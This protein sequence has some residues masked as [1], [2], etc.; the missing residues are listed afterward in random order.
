MK[1]I[2]NVLRQM[3]VIFCFLLGISINQYFINDNKGFLSI[4]IFTGIYA[5]WFFYD[6]FKKK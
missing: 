4:L 3:Y 6:L 2:V 5:L 1:K